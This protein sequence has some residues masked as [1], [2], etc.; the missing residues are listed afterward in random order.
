M[1]LFEKIETLFNNYKNAKINLEEVINN[2]P[3]PKLNEQPP[4][5][6][7]LAVLPNKPY[8]FSEYYDVSKYHEEPVATYVRNF[9][10]QGKAHEEVNRYAFW[11]R[12]ISK[13]QDAH[14]QGMDAERILSNSNICPFYKDEDYITIIDFYKVLNINI[15]SNNYKDLCLEIIKAICDT[16]RFL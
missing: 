15:E 6:R 14:A 3:L 16:P 8:L 5:Y 4:L 10:K 13:I 12:V 9:M 7:S 1:V 2:F 11:L